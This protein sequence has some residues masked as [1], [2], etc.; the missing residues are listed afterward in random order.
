[1][2]DDDPAWTGGV[3]PSSNDDD[4]GSLEEDFEV[5]NDDE[6]IRELEDSG[7]DSGGMVGKV[8]K[9]LLDDDFVDP[10]THL[11]RAPYFMNASGKKVLAIHQVF[12][13]AKHFNEVL[14]DYAIE[15]GFELTKIKNSR[16]RVTAK[17]RA[18][19]CLFRDHASH[20]PDGSFF[21]IK[22]L[23][24]KHTC[25]VVKANKMASSRWIATRLKTV[26]IW[27]LVE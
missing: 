20:S 26:L 13:D 11:R 24:D 6:N 17:C 10:N 19:G 8:R 25:Q 5:E 12:R 7:E 3:V 18:D 27:M 21:V 14:L 9:P 15:N 16:F 2:D 23:T 4:Y 22:T 1:M